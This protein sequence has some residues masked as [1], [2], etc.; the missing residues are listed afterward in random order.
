MRSHTGGAAVL[1]DP[2]AQS[3]ARQYHG[4]GPFH[5]A[6]DLQRAALRAAPGRDSG[7]GNHVEHPRSRQL[8]G[9]PKVSRGTDALARLATYARS[10]PLG[11]CRL[12][13]AC[14]EA[15]DQQGP[16]QRRAPRLLGERVHCREDRRL[17]GAGLPDHKREPVATGTGAARAIPGHLSRLWGLPRWGQQSRGQGLARR[18]DDPRPGVPDRALRG[19][20]GGAAVL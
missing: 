18:H 8:P 1:S 7:R 19:H 3:D 2:A 14:P 11:D 16:G 6:P 13:E 15:G 12:L 5:R 4:N 17:S 9:S 10:G 20:P